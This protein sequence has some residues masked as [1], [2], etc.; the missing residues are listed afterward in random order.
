MPTSLTRLSTRH[1][2]FELNTIVLVVMLCCSTA[3]CAMAEE[4]A[5]SRFSFNGFGTLGLTHS[6]VRNAD[7][8]GLPSQLDGTGYTR[9]WAAGIDSKLGVQGD[10]LI[11]DQLSAV[12]QLVSQHNYDGT[13]RPQV[14]WANLGYQVTPDL[15][16]R[17]GRT[18][19]APFML[20]DTRMVAYTYAWV[21]PP[22]DVY[23]GYP[24]T[25]MDGGDVHYRLR[26]GNVAHSLSA[27][28]GQTT[29]K[30]PYDGKLEARDIL[31]VADEMEWG[32][33]TLR[34]SYATQRA[35]ILIPKFEPIF[36]GFTQFGAGAT[37]FGFADAG[38]QATA[39]GAKYLEQYETLQRFSFASAGVSYD[40]GNW[41]LMSEWSTTKSHGI[42]A[43]STAWYV[44]GSYRFDRL[45]PYLTIANLESTQRIEPGISTAGLPSQLAVAASALN[46]G[47]NS[48]LLALAPSQSS[49]SV[50]ARWD[51]WKNTDLKL[52]YDRIRLRQ[53]SQG[54]LVN[55]Q[56]GFQ[57]AD[58]VNVFSVAMDFVF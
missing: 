50:G 58:D 48:F 21:R 12:M 8:V 51:L 26:T 29:A 22:Q 43:D 1:R 4:S 6:D 56:P 18:V 2:S 57:P 47:L 38:V 15:S 31:H 41:L 27:A 33:F 24:I 54:R 45:T 34:L 20:S 13:W 37:A 11:T 17:A 52:Q 14:E 28:Y 32:P 39:L 16:I 46:T 5:A 55:V 23:A 42:L 7:F 9:A 49:A 53:N 35:R 19:T 40:S 25:N 10:V 36:P 30:F 3:T 44:S